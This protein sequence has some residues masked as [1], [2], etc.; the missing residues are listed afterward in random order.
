MV[1]VVL[2]GIEIASLPVCIVDHRD[3]IILLLNR[4]QICLFSNAIVI[5]R[6]DTLEGLGT[7]CLD[8]I[9]CRVV[10]ILRFLNRCL[11]VPDAQRSF[12]IYITDTI[13]LRIRWEKTAGTSVLLVG[14]LGC[15]KAMSSSLAHF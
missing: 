15:L 8:N 1:Q 12:N 7:G 6:V 11:T 4:C 13:S 9:L 5:D 2:I 14:E 3:A 10:A